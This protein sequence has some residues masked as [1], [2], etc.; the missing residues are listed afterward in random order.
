MNNLTGLLDLDSM[1]HIVANVQYSA[2]NRSNSTTVKQH[3]QR[4]IAN[5]LKNSR[6]KD[7]IMFYQKLGHSNYRNVILP[8][9]KEHRKTS[10]AITLWKPVILEAFEEVGAFGLDYI[11][12]DD[13]QSILADHI[14]YDK[15]V[16]I[17]GDKD[18][19]QIP[20]VIYNPFKK[21]LKPEQRWYSSEKMTALRF[22]WQQ[23]LSGDPTDM[24]GDLCG[25]EGVGEKTAIKLIAHPALMGKVVQEQYTKK[26]G[27][28]VGFERASRTFKMVRLLTTKNN[29]YICKDAEDEVNKLL[30]TYQHFINDVVDPTADLFEPP[31]KAIPDIDSL[32]NTFKNE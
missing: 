28:E 7:V 1:L 6:T 4:F 14:G 24:P 8:R 17:T 3:T 10:E 21:N 27:K 22:L 29:E 12:S 13:A 5:I 25:I 30:T 19:R 15:V 11:E 2:G 20:S 9:Y 31:K 32:F 18:M 26:Y 23:V 16:V